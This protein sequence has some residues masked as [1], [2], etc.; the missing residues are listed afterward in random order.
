MEEKKV[1]RL[2]NLLVVAL[3]LFTLVV[4]VRSCTHALQPPAYMHKVNA[5]RT[6]P[7]LWHK[8]GIIV[9]ETPIR[10][11]VKPDPLRKMIVKDVLH[12]IYFWN[13]V[14]GC[15]LFTL[16][17]DHPSEVTVE[18]SLRAPKEHNW[19]A[20]A[21]PFHGEKP[22]YEVK[23]YELRVSDGLYRATVM[24]HELGH[25]LGLRDLDENP[26]DLM[27]WATSAGVNLDDSIPNYLNN[28]YCKESS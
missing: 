15:E 23:I 10:I 19:V 17:L 6:D 21:T 28:L 25:V 18:M 9:W 11:H 5:K 12:G 2:I 1:N 7:G 16:V 3:C 13:K 22:R 14:V 26:R 20:S 8:N 4:S 27:F 24:A